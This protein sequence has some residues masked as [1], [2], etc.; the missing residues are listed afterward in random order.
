[1]SNRRFKLINKRDLLEQCVENDSY[2]LRLSDAGALISKQAAGTGSVITIPANSGSSSSGAFDSAAFDTG[3]FSNTA[4]SID[5][6]SPSP[7]A[8]KIGTQIIIDNSSGASLTIEIETDTLCWA[9]TGGTGTRTVA[10]GGLAFLLKI[11]ST[12][13]VISGGGIT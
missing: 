5:A 8:F 12:K 13:W 7:A 2:T 9:D 10:D 4:F 6:A 11:A 3:A 1:M